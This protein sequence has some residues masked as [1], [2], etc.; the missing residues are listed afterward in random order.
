VHYFE[1]FLAGKGLPYPVEPAD[2]SLKRYR[3]RKGVD[4]QLFYVAY[5]EA[6]SREDAGWQAKEGDYEWI[7]D[8]DTVFDSFDVVDVVEAQ[9]GDEPTPAPD[10][11]PTCGAEHT[12]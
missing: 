9:P 11:C 8:G 2:A 12:E 1:G 4:A 5:V 10:K 6:T 3:V 7:P